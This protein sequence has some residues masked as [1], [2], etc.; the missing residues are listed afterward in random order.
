MWNWAKVASVC[1]FWGVVVCAG[2]G[3]AWAQESPKYQ[4]PPAAIVQLVDAALTP[5]VSVAPA[6]KSGEARRILIEQ[7]SGLP[8]IADLAQPELRL[9]GL[10]FNP[11]T[12]GP[13]RGRYITSLKLQTLPDG[14]EIA[15]T[16]L[17][18][19]AKIRFVAWSP[20]GRKISVVNISDATGD[21]GLSLWIVDA[22]SAK[23]RRVAGVA[24]N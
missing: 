22:A 6:G 9:A 16:D 24:P 23:A 7:Y 17:P 8:P 4:E 15:V 11:K 18:T 21:A 1:A 13:S 3:L 2:G 5:R 12:N 19:Q 20:D 10:R 14:K